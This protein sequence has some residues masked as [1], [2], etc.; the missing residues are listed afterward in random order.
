MAGRHAEQPYTGFQDIR[1]EA[2]A[3]ERNGDFLMSGGD[4]R[5]SVNGDWSETYFCDLID[6]HLKAQERMDW[7]TGTA[8][9]VFKDF[10]TPLRP[11]NPVPYVNQKGVVERDLTKKEPYY[12]FQSYWSKQPMVRI[13]GHS[14]TTRWGAPGERRPVRV[15]SNCESAELFVNGESCGVKQRD[16]QCFPCAGLYWEV[17]FRE[18]ANTVKVIAQKDGVTVSDEVR[19]RY[20]TEP[21]S[22]PAYLRLTAVSASD[23]R[24]SLEVEALDG[25]HRFCPDAALFVRFSL[26]GEGRL[27]DNLGTAGGSRY[28][29]LAN[30]RASIEAEFT[31]G[32]TAAVCVAGEAV[33]GAMVVLQ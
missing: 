33:K 23:G 3:D 9:W 24:V 26:A 29:Q 30:G 13:Y 15:Y 11:D 28:V 2:T 31:P 7:L 22:E 20:Q 14:W 27:L 17:P 4:P 18:G 19:F 10:S 16:S 12:V 5:V 25:K 8:Q 21:W 1:C 6:W 32:G